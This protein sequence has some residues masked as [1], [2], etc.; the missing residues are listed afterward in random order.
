MSARQKST[1]IARIERQFNPATADNA[2]H[3]VR[4]IAYTAVS[5]TVGGVVNTAL[6][7]NPNTTSEWG[8]YTN[9]YDEFRVVGVRLSLSSTQQYSVTAINKMGAVV[10]DNDDASILTSLTSA[11]EYDTSR[12]FPAVFQHGTSGNENK[13]NL[14]QF[15]WS[16]PTGGKNTAITWQD[17]GTPGSSPGGVKFYFSN[18]TASLAYFDALIEYFIEFRG[19]R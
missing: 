16:R 10:Y 4:L 12:P 18:L 9:I 17:V 19:R 1:P 15:A 11:L 2:V 7:M 8:S 5:S 3:R 6:S 14:L 13:S